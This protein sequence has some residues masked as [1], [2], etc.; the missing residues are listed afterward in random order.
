M[1]SFASRAS[2]IWSRKTVCLHFARRVIVEIVEADFAPGD[3]FGMFARVR[4]SS[5]RCCWRDFFGFVRMNADGGVNPVVLFGEREGGVEFFRAGAGADGEERGD[6]CRAGAL[7]AWL[8]GRPR[9]AGSRCARES[10]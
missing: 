6:A 7:A 9:I 1:G 8:R 2:S 3:D 10:R 5:S 4:A